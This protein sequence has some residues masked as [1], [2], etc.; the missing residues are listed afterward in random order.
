DHQAVAVEDAAG[1]VAGDLEDR[2]IGRLR[3]DDLHLL[4]G[5]EQAVL[6]DLERCGVH[7]GP[8]R[9]SGLRAH[10]DGSMRMNP[11]SS[12]RA[13]QPGGTTMVLSNV[14][15]FA[16]PATRWPGGIRPRSWTCA[17]HSPPRSNQ[18][19]RVPFRLDP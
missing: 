9:E 18:A 6:D 5:L 12:L 14:S 1:I 13:T 11:L 3:Q 2:R 19:R 17:S 4:R 8:D 16:G 15:M 10:R 7:A